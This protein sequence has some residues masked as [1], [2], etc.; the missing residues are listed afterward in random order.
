MNIYDAFQEV[1]NN[2]ELVAEYNRLFEKGFRVESGLGQHVVGSGLGLPIAL[3]IVESH[4]GRVWAE[5][6][7]GQGSIF[8][9]TLPL[10][11]D[12][13]QDHG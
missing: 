1:V 3:T 11:R 7:L 2:K 10:V 9:F 13:E 5:S 4:G 12:E 8:Y 6:K